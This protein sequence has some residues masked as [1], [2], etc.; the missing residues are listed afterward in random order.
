M[1][2][3]LL[4]NHPFVGASFLR[5]GR[6]HLVEGEEDGFKGAIPVPEVD[7]LLTRHVSIL[8]LGAIASMA[9]DDD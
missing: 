4:V 7:C 6:A 1:P 3:H 5:G 8:V 9:S 2:S